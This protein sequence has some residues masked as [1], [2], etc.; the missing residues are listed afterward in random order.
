MKIHPIKYFKSNEFWKIFFIFFFSRFFFFL[1]A[2]ISSYIAFDHKISFESA[3]VQWDSGWYLGII[4]NGYDLDPHTTLFDPNGKVANWAFFPLY[5]LFSYFIS[6]AFN[7]SPVVSSL[8]LSNTSFFISLFFLYNY[9]FKVLGNKND[10]IY[11]VALIS[12]SPF[13]IYYSVIYTEALYLLLMIITIHSCICKKWLMAA[14]SASLLSA[15]R[16]LGI[17]II[18]PMLFISINQ[19]GIK[20]FLNFS[21]ESKKSIFALLFTPIGLALYMLFL[22]QHTGDPLAFKNIQIAWGREIE[23]PFYN[24]FS[25][26]GT[27][28]IYF[29]Y[30]SLFTILG[31]ILS[32]NLLSTPL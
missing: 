15:T 19:F 26:M 24:L 32:F 10:A 13:S 4:T 22:Y 9:T 27:G 7:L 16:N 14:L 31:I 28:D 8:I 23:N 6:K 30:C 18:F 29:L 1:S 5:P 21:K 25:A 20:S 17:F 12:F 2:Y 11:I 3:I